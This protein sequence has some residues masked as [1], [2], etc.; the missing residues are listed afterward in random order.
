MADRK[1]P[2]KQADLLKRIEEL[3]RRVA[4]L[5]ARPVYVPVYVPSVPLPVH[6][7]YPSLPYIV[8]CSAG[9]TT[10]ESGK[11]TLTQ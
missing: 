1:A 5:E 6:P 8:T 3:E 4:S 2:M 7:T 10:N 11:W 9:Q